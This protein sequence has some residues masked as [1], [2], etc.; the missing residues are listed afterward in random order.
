MG[1]GTGKR[2]GRKWEGQERGQEVQKGSGHFSGFSYIRTY[3]R[4][5]SFQATSYDYI[6]SKGNSQ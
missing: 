6:M 2:R 3:E 1:I 5:W 4:R